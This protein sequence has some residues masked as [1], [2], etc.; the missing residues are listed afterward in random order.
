MSR[1]SPGDAALEGFQVIARHWR[2]V[3]G[4]A[5]F[6]LLAMVAMVTTTVIVL[7]SFATVGGASLRPQLAGQVSGAIAALGY[8][9]TQVVI[10]TGLYRLML[11][12]TEPGFLHLRLGRT[13]LRVFVGF[14]APA[15]A[16]APLAFAVTLGVGA[17][18]E[19]SLPL[20]MLCAAVGM[21]LVLGVALRFALVPVIGFVEGGVPMAP[22]WRLSRGNAWLLLGMA[23]LVASLL[24]VIGAAI[25]LA[26][27][28]LGGLLTG[29]DDLGLSGAESL[30][31]HPG[32][33]ALQIVAELALAP[34]FLV[35]AQAPFVAV[36]RALRDP[37]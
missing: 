13:E 20:A 16:L 37:D 4:W 21:V 10:V 32:R 24:A 2:V 22:A 33:Y 23:L 6:N 34:V 19:R 8:G 12:P 29:F 18:G 30:V 27:F 5:A 35:I 17:V 7:V 9:L 14:L 25:W 15:V 11:R 3:V 1:F 28:V 26:L 36:Y 31:A